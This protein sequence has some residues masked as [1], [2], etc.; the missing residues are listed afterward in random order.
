MVSVNTRL[1][2]IVGWLLT[3]AGT[4]TTLSG[5]LATS[6]QFIVGFPSVVWLGVGAAV[7]GLCLVKL[8]LW[9]KEP[10]R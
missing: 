8:G 10:S 2:N 4:L 5:V 7:A 9:L 3:V 1:R 6:Y